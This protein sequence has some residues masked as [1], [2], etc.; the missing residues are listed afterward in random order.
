MGLDFIKRILAIVM[1]VCIG[2][3]YLTINK[4]NFCKNH[5]MKLI[6][7]DKTVDETC[8]IIKTIS[9][10]EEH[11]EII[12]TYSI[13]ID[14]INYIINYFNKNKERVFHPDF[15]KTKITYTEFMILNYVHGIL[16]LFKIFI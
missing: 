13:F 3:M 11:T 15:I 6:N 1:I 16:F 5:R 14:S 8:K 9:I 7:I 12:Q 4:Y 10:I 2:F